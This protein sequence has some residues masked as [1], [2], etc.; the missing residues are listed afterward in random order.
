VYHRFVEFSA[1]GDAQRAHVAF[2]ME[3]DSLQYTV[4]SADSHVIEPP[5]LWLKYMERKF[6]ERA[7]H[8]ERRD[9]NDYFVVTPGRPPSS[10]MAL[11]NAGQNP[12]ELRATSRYD[13]IRPGGWDPDARLLDM[14]QDGVQAEVVYP[15]LGMQMFKL[16]DMAFQQ[17]CMQAYNDWVADFG[18]VHPKRLK[19]V[20]MVSV[21]DIAWAVA[22]V[23]RV[24][25]K[26]LVGVMIPGTPEADKGY[27][28]PYY[29]PLWAA[30]QELGLPVSLH[31]VTGKR[32]EFDPARFFSTYGT[33]PHFIAESITDMLFSGVFER[34]PKLRIVSAENDAGWIGNVLE[35]LDHF[36]KRYRYARNVHL[37][38]QLLPSDVFR[39]HVSATF[40]R[41][42]SGVKIRHEIGLGNIMWSSD[43]PHSD[44]TWPNSQAVLSEHFAGVPEQEKRMIV[45]EN[46]ARLYGFM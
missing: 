39:Q 41:D 21:D 35:R 23:R 24:A 22:E 18:S 20:A 36:Y 6:K 8:V 42:K 15:S 16:E 13:E 10:M 29:D 44:S 14:A 32:T 37:P 34:F 5:D 4:V 43:Y 2:K 33:L 27:N 31:A 19:G 25:K 26:G 46:A 7:P 38:G 17:A 40:I 28:T 3:K 45:C 11:A 30:A 12:K 9:G 1:C